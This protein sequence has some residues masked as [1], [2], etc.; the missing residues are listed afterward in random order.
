MDVSG[1]A[2][3]WAERTF[4]RAALGDERRVARLV[5][6]AERAARCPAGPVTRVFD[7]SAD[8]EGAFRLLENTAVG[9]AAVAQAAFE[10]TA[11]AAAGEHLL[12]VPVD[13]SSLTL[14]DRAGKRELGPVGNTRVTSRGLHVLS[15]LA[16]DAAGVVL[17][18]LDQV[19][20]ARA[21]Q[22]RP[23]PRHD[24]CVNNSHLRKETRFWLQ[25]L[26]NCDE[27]LERH[28]AGARAWYQLDRGADCWPVFRL[29]LQRKL[30]VTVRASHDRRLL[31]TDGRVAHLRE[32]LKRQP[33]LGRYDVAIPARPHRD[34]R[35]ARMTVR[36]CTVRIHA[37]TKSKGREVFVLNAV[38]AQESGRIATDRLC[39]V[40]LTTHA[41]NSFEDARAV[42]DGYALRWR[43]EEF[44]RAWKRGG[45]NV[46]ES[47]L[48]SRSALIKWATILATVAAR[49]V[50]LAYLA[51]TAAPDLP[52]T[53]EFSE[54]E[55]DAAFL[56]VK[57]K[58]DRRKRV[59]LRE[60]IDIIA[61]VGGFAHK[62]S[63][64]LPGPTILARGLERIETL[65]LGLKNQAEMR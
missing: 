40:L 27:R 1:E 57:R 29:V 65:A 56:Y 60:I 13:G 3:E 44:H 7:S 22:P 42:I 52:A 59:L 58:R 20:W 9:A 51:R 34:A 38:L 31:E 43:V 15:A 63:D 54:Y 19:W 30:L 11:R 17:G 49:A 61:E 55:I 24:K 47:Q 33:I 64:K 4:G 18:L 28:A 8:R 5:A 32:K 53:T 62:Y 45:C 41:V 48:Q 14:S 23:R 10:G 35:T 21:Q 37:R 50:R 25:A 46:E 2:A 12:Y 16:V 6:M 39:W 26:S 36:A